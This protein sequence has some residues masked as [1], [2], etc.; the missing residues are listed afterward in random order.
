MHGTNGYGIRA[1]AL[2]P[3]AKTL[4]TGADEGQLRLFDVDTGKVRKVFPKD[5]SYMRSVAFAPTLI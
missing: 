1:L 4:A 2:S 5:G 3:D